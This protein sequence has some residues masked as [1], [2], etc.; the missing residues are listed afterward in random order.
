MGYVKVKV[1]SATAVKKINEDLAK[2]QLKKDV[3]SVIEMWS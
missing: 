1:R 3:R 2:K